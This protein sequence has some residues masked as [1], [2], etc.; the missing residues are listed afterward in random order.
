MQSSDSI[1]FEQRLFLLLE[2][3]A[4]SIREKE[5]IRSELGLLRFTAQGKPFELWLKENWEWLEK[6]I[7]KPKDN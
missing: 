2:Q 5:W 7:Y 1:L 6:E 4:P 3:R